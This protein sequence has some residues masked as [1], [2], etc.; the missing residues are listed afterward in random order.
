MHLAPAF[1]SRLWKA[2]WCFKVILSPDPAMSAALPLQEVAQSWMQQIEADLGVKLD[3]IGA[4]HR[5]TETPHVQFLWSGRT[6]AGEPVRIDR[7]YISHG[8]RTRAAE[9][10]DLYQ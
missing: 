10:I 7:G 4:V 5:D 8:L 1:L 6:L 3:W 2:P 9:M